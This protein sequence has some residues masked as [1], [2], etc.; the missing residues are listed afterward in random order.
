MSDYNPARKKRRGGRRMLRR[1]TVLRDLNDLE[2]RYFSALTAD[3][4][5]EFASL[6]IAVRDLVLRGE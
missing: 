2:S 6:G 3:L 1:M 4:M 5:R